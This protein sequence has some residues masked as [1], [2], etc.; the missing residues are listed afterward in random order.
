ML[1]AMD[2]GKKNT[3]K[4]GE[5]TPAVIESATLEIINEAEEILKMYEID[6]AVI[7]VSLGLLPNKKRKKKS[8][9]DQGYKLSMIEND[10][11]DMAITYEHPKFK[12]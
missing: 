2:S 1:L 6:G 7:S 5:L 10:D 4:G 8:T 11:F 3:M 9:Q 12:K